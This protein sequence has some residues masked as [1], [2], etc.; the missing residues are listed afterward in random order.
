MD[1]ILFGLGA[2]TL[3][4]L[5]TAVTAARD[6]K[7]SEGILK[8]YPVAGSTKVYAGTLVGLNSAGYLTSML[9]STASMKFAGV[10]EE[11]IDASGSATDGLQSCRVREEGEW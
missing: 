5:G 1:E 4:V 10:A 2:I 9:H 11:T 8:A 6:A 3:F 7:R